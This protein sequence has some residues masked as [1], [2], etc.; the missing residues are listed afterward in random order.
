M[1]SRTLSGWG[2]HLNSKALLL[3]VGSRYHTRNA[4]EAVTVTDGNTVYKRIIWA[5]P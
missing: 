2:T 3:R 5:G 4:T 1:S